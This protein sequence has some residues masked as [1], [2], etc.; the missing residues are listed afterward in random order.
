MRAGCRDARPRGRV[1]PSDAAAHLYDG[2]VLY[3]HDR[4]TAPRAPSS[5]AAGDL[6]ETQLEQRLTATFLAILG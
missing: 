1:A 3:Q 4:T 2:I 5:I 6:P